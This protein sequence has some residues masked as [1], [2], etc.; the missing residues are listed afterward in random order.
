VQCKTHFSGIMLKGRALT[1]G[2]KGWP[3]G[4]PKPLNQPYSSHSLHLSEKQHFH[5]LFSFQQSSARVWLSFFVELGELHLLHV[6]QSPTNTSS[7][8]TLLLQF[9]LELF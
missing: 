3:K 8:L 6:S 7:F 5:S 1:F 9:Q 4:Y 2:P